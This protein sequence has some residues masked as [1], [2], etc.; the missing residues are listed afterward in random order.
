MNDRS[1]L[2][3]GAAAAV[4]GALLA[5]AGNLLHPR[6]GDIAD[7][8][9]Y[10]KI[11]GSDRWLTSDLL[12]IAALVLSTA[13]LVAIV[14]PRSARTPSRPRTGADRPIVLDQPDE[15]VAAAKVGETVQAAI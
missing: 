11:A 7:V 4:V 14:W 13:G 8:D 10:R 2:R 12:L 5:L 1:F 3:L 6:F 9:L 15:S